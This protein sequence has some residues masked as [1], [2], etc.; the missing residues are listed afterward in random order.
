MLRENIIG[1]NGQITVRDKVM[2]SIQWIQSFEPPDGYEVMFSGGKDSC[3]VITL[4][5]MAGVKFTGRYSLT[6]VDPPELVKFI[7]ETYPDVIVDYPEMTMWQ[8]IVK[9]RMPPTRMV[10]YCC[11]VLKE[12]NGKGKVAITGVRWAESAK[13]KNSRNLVNI[14]V[15]KNKRIVHNDDN[16]EA[17]RSVEQCYRTQK[18]LVNP[19]INWTDEDVWQFINE[20]NVK[21]CSLY[22]EGFKRLGCIGCPLTSKPEE[23]ERWPT[24][25]TAYIH[26]FDRMIAKRIADG[27]PTDWKNGQECFD[28]WVSN[29]EK[30]DVFESQIEMEVGE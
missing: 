3:V 22:D 29:A 17:R 11:E 26:A 4:A 9:K 19:I 14:G 25:R 30:D 2:T 10:R 15:V 16:D 5:Q 28:W 13:R 1:D 21:Y 23:F 12:R 24:Y 6:T 27:M 20:Y 7:K 8:L 18:T